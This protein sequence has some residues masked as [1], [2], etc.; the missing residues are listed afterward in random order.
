MRHLHN[1]RRQLETGDVFAIFR[2][3]PVDGQTNL[4]KRKGILLPSEHRFLFQRL[5][6]GIRIGMK[7]IQRLT[8]LLLILSELL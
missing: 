7:L 2:Q 8:Q 4:E 5:H 6:K 3:R 1:L